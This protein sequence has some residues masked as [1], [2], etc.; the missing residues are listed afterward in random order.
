MRHGKRQSGSREDQD[1]QCQSE[2]SY[3]AAEWTGVQGGWPPREDQKQAEKC[4]L[5]I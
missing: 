5:K 2:D 4:K 1:E 3:G